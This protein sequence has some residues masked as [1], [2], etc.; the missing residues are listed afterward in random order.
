LRQSDVRI[1][2]HKG[3]VCDWGLQLEVQAFDRRDVC[4][5]GGV[6][7][8]RPARPIS[9]T[10]CGLNTVRCLHPARWQRPLWASD[11]QSGVRAG[12]AMPGLFPF[13]AEPAKT[14]RAVGVCVVVWRDFVTMAACSLHNGFFKDQAREDE[15]LQIIAAYKPEDQ[16]QI[17]WYVS[18]S[19]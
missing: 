4:A 3:R 6:R 13:P 15:Y 7:Q 16:P 17:Q 2:Q 19:D 5:V 11:P 1:A 14:L 9:D 18:G 10:S 8:P 12:G